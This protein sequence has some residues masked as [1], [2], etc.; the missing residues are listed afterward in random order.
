MAELWQLM[1][2]VGGTCNQQGVLGDTGCED[3]A[4]L[5]GYKILCWA[6][7]PH[8]LSW[9]HWRFLRARHS[10]GEL[11]LLFNKKL[12]VSLTPRRGLFCALG[13]PQGRGPCA[14]RQV[15]SRP[16][17]FPRQGC[18]F[19][20]CPRVALPP[21]RVFSSYVQFFTIQYEARCRIL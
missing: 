10:L 19:R 5:K 20:S 15:P 6:S 21:P 14:G 16:G 13:W 12:W 1:A 3:S 11:L 18:S 2:H 9:T 8:S 7:W 4:L 17:T